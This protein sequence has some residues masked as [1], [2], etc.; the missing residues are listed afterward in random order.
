MTNALRTSRRSCCA[1]L[2]DSP[3]DDDRCALE[4]VDRLEGWGYIGLGEKGLKFLSADERHSKR[5]SSD[6]AQALTE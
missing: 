6:K 1:H 5:Q 2:L 3:R 4:A